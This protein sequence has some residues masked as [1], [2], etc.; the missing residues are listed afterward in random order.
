M[1]GAKDS[2]SCGIRKQ[3]HSGLL[4]K[5]SVAKASTSHQSLIS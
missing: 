4:H 5:R 3:A 1:E 2:G